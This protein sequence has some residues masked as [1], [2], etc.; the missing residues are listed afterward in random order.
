MQV[1]FCEYLNNHRYTTDCDDVILDISSNETIYGIV[2]A[3]T[4][5]GY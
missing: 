4:P 5:L 3:L 2:L 1:S